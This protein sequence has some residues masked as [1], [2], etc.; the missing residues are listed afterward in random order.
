MKKKFTLLIA[1]LALLT[2]MVQPGRAMGQTKDDVNLHYTG[3]TTFT[4]V[5]ETNYA[6]QLNLSESDWSVTGQKNDASN[7]TACNKDGSIRLYPKS[8]N[9]SSITITNLNGATISTI[10]F[11]MQLNSPTVKV[12][13]NI[14]EP[15][16]GVYTINSDSFVVIN[17]IDATSGNQV[18]IKSIT[19][20][21]STGGNTPSIS[22]SNVEIAYDA[23]QGSIEYSI[24]NGVDGGTLTASTESDWLTLGTVGET[25]PFTCSANTAAAER[26]ATVTLTYTYNTDQ[27]VTKTVTVTQDG[28]PNVIYTTIPELFAAAT[29]TETNVNVTFG[30]WVISGVSGNNA[31]VTDNSGNGFIIYKSGHGFAVN[32]KLSGTVTGTPLKLYQGS[33][34]FT[35]L[36]SSTTGLT[37]SGDGEIT[38]IT[39]KTIADLGGVNTGAVIT[40]SNLN[41]DGTNLSDGTNTIKPYNTLYSGMSFT[42]GKTYNVTGVYIQYGN[43]KEIAPRGA[44]DIVE[45]TAPSLAA[46]DV[47]IAY[48]A[49]EGDITYTLENPAQDGVL[50]A[51]ITAGNEGNWL[52]L[53]T[54]GQNVP[55]TCTAN[56]GAER[57]ATVTL[58]YTYNNAAET[59]TATAV[60]TQAAYVAPVASITVNPAIVNATAAETEGTITVTYENITTVVA[61][62]YFCDAQGVAT[63]Y[64]WV[65]AEIDN[66]DNVYYTIDANTGEARTAYFKV[67]AFDDATNIVYSNL[68]TINQAAP[69][70]PGTW[71]LTDL[72][73][74][75]ANDI[76]V[77]VGDNGDTY[78][79]PYNGGGQSGAPAA[80][81]IAIANDALTAEPAAELQWNISGNATDG[82]VFYPNGNTESWLYCTDANN[83]V[84]VGT[85]D[86]KTF[87]L[88]SESGY[89][90]NTATSRYVGI[91]NSQDWRCY[92]NTT[93]NIAGQTFAFYKKVTGPVPVVPTIT[94]T[95]PEVTNVPAAGDV[96][97]HTVT[98]ANMTVT[99]TDDFEFVYCDSEGNILDNQDPK[100]NWIELADA[101][102]SL[103]SNNVYNMVYTVAANEETTPRTGYFKIGVEQTSGTV[104]SNLVTVTQA[105]LVV[106]YA[107]LPF[108]WEGGLP[109]A[110]DALNGTTLSGVGS[111]PNQTTYQMKLDGTDD[112]I[113]VKTDSQP[114]KVTIGVKMIG[115]ATTSYITVKA[116]TDGDTFDDGE[117]LAISGNSGSIVNL[118]TTRTFNADVRYVKMVFTKG[119]NV[120][121]GPITI[122]K[123]TTDPII[124]AEDVDLAYDAT[125]GEIAYTITNPVAGKNLEATTSATWISNIAV[126]EEKVSFTTTANEGS[127]DRIAT[128]TLT[129]E[130]AADKTVIVTQAHFVIDYATIPFAYDGNG[131]GELPVGLTPTGLGT[132][133]S[134]PKMKFDGAGDNLILKLD[135]APTSLSY[136]I[137]GNG[138]G[139][140]SWAG[141]FKVQTSA[142]GETYEDLVVYENNLGATQSITHINLASTVRYIKWVYVTKTT[143]NVALGNIHASDEYEIYGDMTINSDD[144]AA[145][146]VIVHNGSVVT[147]VGTN[148]NAA[149]LIIEDGGQLIHDGDG[150][151]A[152]IQKNITGYNN[153]RDAGNSNYQLIASPVATSLNVATQT[154]L[155][156]TT[157][158]YDLYIFNENLPAKEWRNYK[159]TGEFTTIDNGK[160]YLY[161]NASNDTISFAGALKSSDSDVTVNLEYTD[162][163]RF[164][165][166]NLVGNPFACN[167]YAK[168]T[169]GKTLAFYKMNSTGN[170][171]VAVTN[172]AIAPMEGVFVKASATGQSFAFTRQSPVSSPGKGNLIIQVAQAVTGRDAQHISDN[173]IIRFD[174]GNN[175]EKFSFNDN[176]DKL[177]FTLGNKDYSVFNAEAR[178]EM[179]V[180]FK[181]AENGTYTIDFSMDNVEFS[182]L[183]LIDNKTGMDI[184]LLQTSSYTFE[185]SK[186]DYA[187][188]FKLVFSTNNNSNSNDD[189]SFAFFDANG[190]LL[191]LGNEGTATLQVI[192]ITGRTVSNETFSGNYSKAINAKA[193]VYMLRL[194]Q[195]NDVRTQKIVVR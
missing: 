12:G 78:A 162:G 16:D 89:L 63:T 192:D 177:Y 178:G 107:T 174:G 81:T 184:D 122:T 58:T 41:Y 171:F 110:F 154:N 69:V 167:A 158:E 155:I 11:V 45:I 49:T 75:T 51:E 116:S 102:Y 25:V 187:S 76:F 125:S 135:A 27:T 9:G 42:N 34:E 37:V 141:T 111:Y 74:L 112:F 44:A 84:R 164:A 144:L 83:G 106:D 172:G 139:S 94:I 109:D 98:L 62:V 119:S 150:V 123:Y 90:Q 95:P 166:W 161:A 46:E 173:A 10:S 66:D 101:E 67:S 168:D 195:G 153:S 140:D 170:G 1:A 32:D 79:M 131:T 36:T 176:G 137:K 126:S 121:V 118:E 191:I 152:T 20:N 188:R 97:E 142:D 80:V 18:Q 72:A 134:S 104:Y 113:M 64:E 103:V 28:N 151:Q 92:T 93:G 40:L 91:Y 6:S 194:I 13:N 17:G 61:E 186:I 96:P 88:D 115:G 169:I 31:Y 2:M 35:N 23:T 136:D 99:S 114:A 19:I 117:Q 3:S 179:P 21:Y 130:G 190:N 71:V 50:T 8:G 127:E 30:N 159:Q 165:G 157:S 185:A 4:W 65:D 5:A 156:S 77:I 149:D 26:T 54:V 60:V 163:N 52:T 7:M 87:V 39:N 128:F 73:D 189:N 43:T 53:G 68:V 59:K 100:P 132:Y 145:Q 38:V 57:T 148:T 160:G 180:N 120:G 24:N 15:S 29:S 182:Y 147:F 47:S 175:L 129:Y 183:H 124:N 143:G 85:N 14:I 86:N 82:Y 48:D 55:F 181:A 70:T 56:T 146:P 108:E 22:A 193:G 133:N 138:S 33:A 105:G